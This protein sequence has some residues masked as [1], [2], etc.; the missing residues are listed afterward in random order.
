[1]D[2]ARRLIFKLAGPATASP[3]KIAGPREAALPKDFALWRTRSKTLQR[4]STRFGP[5]RDNSFRST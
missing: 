2:D 1:M 4:L 5:S 3:K